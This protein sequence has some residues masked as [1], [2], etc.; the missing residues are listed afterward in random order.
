M[1]KN[2][3]WI[4]AVAGV[5]FW[6]GLSTKDTNVLSAIFREMFVTVTI[7]MA[8]NDILCFLE[9]VAYRSPLFVGH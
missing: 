1:N 6:R 9:G 3:N 5:F 4:R 8:K 7:E 2:S